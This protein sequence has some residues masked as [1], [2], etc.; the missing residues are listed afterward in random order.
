M[1]NYSGY[2]N[3]IGDDD[4]SSDNT[5]LLVKSCGHYKLIHLKKMHTIREEG[6]Q[7]YQL[8][9][10]AE[11]IAHFIIGDTI[12]DVGK[13]GVFIY[14]PGVPQN[15]YYILPENPDIYWLHFTG[16]KVEELLETLGLAS[17]QP[18]QLQMREEL[19]ELFEKIIVELRFER[20][21]NLE[22]AE[23]YFRQLLIL[24]ARHD[25]L[26][27]E[28]KQAYN[29]LFDGVV[30]RFHHDYQKDINIAAF[31]DSYHISCSWFIREFKKYTGY[32]PKQY[33]TNLR[34]QHAKEL[35]NNH[36]LSISDISSL[37][38][39]DNQLYFSR[40]FHKYIGMSPSEYR[41]GED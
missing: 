2:Y 22:M 33:I 17:E 26:G 16:R 19:P 25:Q 7:D 32:S 12:Y 29:S 23:A 39:Y 8:L 20:Y 21:K 31:A 40:I 4:M 11:G 5:D 34:L 15:Y 30:N 10:V 36:Y 9:Y 1:L 38:G 6:R 14:K 41:D 35:L 24:L 18:Q 13:G 28:E 27:N 3:K 37:V